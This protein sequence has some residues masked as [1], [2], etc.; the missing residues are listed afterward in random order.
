VAAREA[1]NDSCSAL[2][3]AFGHVTDVDVVV[4]GSY[5]WLWCGG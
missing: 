4:M 3:V 2:L 1:W 5:L